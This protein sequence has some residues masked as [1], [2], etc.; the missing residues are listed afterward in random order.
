MSAKLSASITV[1]TLPDLFEQKLTNVMM[2]ISVA[3]TVMVVITLMVGMAVVSI[4][5]S[6][7]KEE[8]ADH[9]DGGDDDNADADDADYANADTNRRNADGNEARTRVD[10][11]Q[12][13]ALIVVAWSEA[14]KPTNCIEDIVGNPNWKASDPTYHTENVSIIMAC[15]NE[16]I[17]APF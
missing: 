17:A 11:I 9:N 3:M 12:K 4:M 1:A 5:M 16:K 8:N 14:I 7:V 6:G 15:S 2:M 13:I 10:W